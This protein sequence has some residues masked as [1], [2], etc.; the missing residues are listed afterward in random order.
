MG[1][2]VFF[3]LTSLLWKMNIAKQE[4]TLKKQAHYILGL[5]YESINCFT[6]RIVN[7]CNRLPRNAVM[8]ASIIQ[9]K[10]YIDKYLRNR[11]EDDTS[12]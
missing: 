11:A 1:W 12:Q 2:M 4:G 3:M 6:Q 5:I 7:H 8:S 9:F 10:G